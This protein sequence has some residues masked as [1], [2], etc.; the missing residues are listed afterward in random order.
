MNIQT[1]RYVVQVGRIGSISKAAQY[2]YISQP[3]LSRAIHEIEASTGITLFNRTNKGVFPTYDG[4]VFL[5]KAERL[6]ENFDRLQGEYFCEEVSKENESQLKIVVAGGSTPAFCAW[7]ECCRQYGETNGYQDLVFEEQTRDEVLQMVAGD[8]YNLGIIHYRAMRESYI[9][10]K[11]AEMGLCCDILDKTAICAQIR[12]GHPL[13]G[14]ENVSLEE[15]SL[16]PRVVYNGDDV[17]EINYS[18]DVRQ[19]NRNILKKR[20]MVRSRADLRHVVEHT[21]AYYLGSD[22]KYRFP[23][24]I[25][26][27]TTSIPLRDIK[28]PIYTSYLY[29]RNHRFSTEEKQFLRILKEILKRDLVNH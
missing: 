29:K 18:S 19:Y 22:M 9:I 13:E 5:E 12:K 7:V 10:E 27:G 17:S 8:I 15:L 28:D 23:D 20:I 6:L 11:C 2:L 21:D 26:I 3:T 24:D 25:S 16:Y 1:L 4:T 14:K